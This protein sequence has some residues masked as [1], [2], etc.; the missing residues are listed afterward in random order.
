MDTHLMYGKACL[1]LSMCKL[2]CYDWER[3]WVLQVCEV[4]LIVHPYRRQEYISPRACPISGIG[5]CIQAKRGKYL[6]AK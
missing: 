1:F 2:A 4:E 6:A 3:H 5:A